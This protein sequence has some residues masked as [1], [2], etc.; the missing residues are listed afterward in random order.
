LLG[1]PFMDQAAGFEPKEC[2]LPEFRSEVV[3]E[4][5]LI[6]ITFNP[7]AVS[8]NESLAS[9][10]ER[11]KA[12]GW[13][14][15]KQVIVDAVEQD[16]KYN[17]KIQIETYMEFYHH[18]G[19]HKDSLEEESPGGR[20]WCEEDKGTWTA[21]HGGRKPNLTPEELAEKPSG[22]LINAYPLLM[23]GMNKKRCGFRILFPVGPN[24][25][26]SIIYSM[27]RPEEIGTPEFEAGRA[28]RKAKSEIVNREDNEVND[29]QQF[30]ALSSVA[31][32]GRFS[33]LEA[34][35]W[36]LAEY[37]RRRIAAY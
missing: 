25:T 10:V 12:E 18:I 31:V 24:R 11:S 37:V 19:A 4:L 8:V 2:R 23:M 17:W 32:V 21:V 36:H 3:D 9:L 34:C 5:G 7:D 20:S 29:M 15:N 26:K 27:A 1:A 16:N 30:G 6:F 33:H 13:E 35:S 22:T 14:M 28:E